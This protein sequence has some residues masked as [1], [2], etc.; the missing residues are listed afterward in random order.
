MSSRFVTILVVLT[1][2]RCGGSR[3]PSAPSSSVAPATDPESALSTARALQLQDR[4]GDAER[5]LDE[6]VTRFPGVSDLVIERAKVLGTLGRFDRSIELLAGLSQADPRVLNLLGYSELLAGRLEA[7]RGHLELAISQA[8]SAG[9]SYPP[10]HYHLGLYYLQTDQLER[11]REQFQLAIDS[12]PAHLEASYQLLNAHE[13]LNRATD[14]DRKR[15]RDLFRAQLALTDALVDPDPAEPIV[16]DHSAEIES[17]PTLESQDVVREVPAGA[18]I[19]I[20]CLPSRSGPARFLVEIVEGEGTGNQLLDVVHAPRG[21]QLEWVTHRIRLP[22]AVAGAKQKLRLRVQKPGFWAGL[23]GSAGPPGSA[24]AEPVALRGASPRSADPRPNVL[25]ISLDTLR[26]DRLACYQA[27]RTTSPAIDR[28]AAQGVRFARAQA[29]SNW[30]LPSHYSMMSGL[31]PAAHGVMPDLESTRGYLFPDRKLAVRGSGREEML[32][33]VLAAQGYWTAAITEN[34]WV[35]GRFGFSQGFSLYRSDLKGSLPSTR[36]AAV[37]QIETFGDHGP[38]FLFVHSYA[39]HTP[40]HA[41]KQYRTRFVAEDHAGFAYPAG[42]VPIKHYNRFHVALF[43]PAPS[44]IVAF[45]DLYD[46]QLG[47]AEEL[48]SGLLELL[49]RKGLREQTLVIVTSDHGEEIFE[50]GQFDHGDTL[51]EEVTR[52]PLIFSWPGALPPGTVVTEPVSMAAIPATVRDLVG[53]GTKHGQFESLRTRWS[54]QSIA[55]PLVFADALGRNAEPLSAVWHER[56]KLIRRQA[57][58]GVR[59]WLFDLEADPAEQRNLV[60][61]RPA[62]SERLRKAL[63]AHARVSEEIRVLLG[64]S[65]AEL[66]PE[67]LEALK[68]LGYAQ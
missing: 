63:E 68:S 37:E 10:A 12:N 28:L 66:D 13:R 52:V 23:F 40:Y 27:G 58:A 15:F 64:S 24:F 46:G 9:R 5:L 44:D 43:P 50:R 26:A 56:W 53:L 32:A 59:E 17:R 34:G 36:Q 19:S 8:Q 22:T 16:V 11:A 45:R 33:E 6:A 57:K 39:P 18:L 25:L 62:E 42:R 30:T 67:T 60:S 35:S 14:S 38:W 65:E 2:L 41:P 54:A 49:D 48:V 1:L 61:A 55:P 47:F 29:P 7:G 31:T 4:P 20:G 21:D 51:F 3:L